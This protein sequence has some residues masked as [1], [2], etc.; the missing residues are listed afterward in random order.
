MDNTSQSSNKFLAYVRVSSKDQSRGTSLVEQKSYIEKYAISKGFIIDKFYG[1]VESASKT[2]REIFD[3]MIKRLKRNHLKG[4][5]F[6]KVDRSARNPK[7]QAML[8][9]LMQQGYELHFVSEGLNTTDPV[10]RNMMYMLWGMASGYSE[11]LKNE[12][13]KGILGRLKQGKY[14]LPPPLGY[15][16]LGKDCTKVI[17]PIKGPIIKQLFQDYGSGNYSG[18]DLIRKA[19]KMGLTNRN[20]QILNRNALYNILSNTF[21]YG[22]IT[23]KKGVFEGEHEPL[24][25]QQLFKKVQY[26]MSQRGFKRNN[27]F[28]YVFRGLLKCSACGRPL[29]VMTSKKRWKYYMCRDWNCGVKTIAEPLLESQVINQL[30]DLEFNSEDEEAFKKALSSFRKTAQKSKEDQLKIL[31]LE[32]NNTESRIQSLLN[33]YIEQKIDEETYSKTRTALLERKNELKDQRFSL[34]TSEDKAL[35]EFDKLVNLLK[36]PVIAYQKAD[37]VNKRRLIT[38]MVEN[39]ELNQKTLVLHWKK[40]F[41]LIAKRPKSSNG[42]DGR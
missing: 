4:I 16:P 32:I 10:G 3:E 7:D 30:H 27:H 22:L 35:E 6:H 13:N 18:Q 28:Q 23:H 41:D 8:Y 42:G 1:E 11:N 39:F 17:D 38:S 37:P 26:V 12:I 25:S 34:D 31:D 40:T 36:S 19:R 24:I 14:P 20:G 33:K 9:D 5:I 29:R 21:Y 15:K 2:G